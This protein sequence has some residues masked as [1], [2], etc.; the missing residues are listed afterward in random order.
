MNQQD[1]LQCLIKL[2]PQV[3]PWEIVLIDL[4][5]CIGAN[6]SKQVINVL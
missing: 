6:S 3:H 4:P 1:S 2:W 5:N